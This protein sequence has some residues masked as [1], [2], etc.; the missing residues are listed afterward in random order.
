MN[1]K[2]TIMRNENIKVA[3]SI[4]SADFSALGREVQKAAKAGADLIH[5]DVMDG[6][7]VPN[8]TMGPLVVKALKKITNLPLDVHLMIDNPEKYVE[9]FIEAGSDIISFHIET[10]KNP[11]KIVEKIK[12]LKAKPAIAVN[13]NSKVTKDLDLLKELYM[14]LFMT[15]YPGFEGQKFMPEVLPK[16]KEFNEFR[17]KNNLKI[18]IEVDGG[19]NGRTARE[20]IDAGANI[21]VAGSA[22]F[23]SKNYKKAIDSIKYAQ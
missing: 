17:Q 8:I 18:N 23:Y 7:F 3:A 11:I 16:I 12:K 4:L 5:V 6:H 22:I 1:L 10:V 20:V 15:V 14:V 19:I 13:P 21:L 9:R 2:K